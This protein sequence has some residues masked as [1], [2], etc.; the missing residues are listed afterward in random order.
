MRGYYDFNRYEDEA[1][2]P[3]TAIYF[4]WE[5]ALLMDCMVLL[6]KLKAK[7]PDLHSLGYVWMGKLA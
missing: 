6:F 1:D 5:A 7:Y 4:C 2:M 3:A